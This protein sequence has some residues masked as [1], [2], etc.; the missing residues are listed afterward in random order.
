MHELYWIDT[1]VS[2][3]EVSLVGHEAHQRNFCS[4][5]Q[6]DAKTPDVLE[7]LKLK[8]GEGRITENQICLKCGKKL[9]AIPKAS[10]TGT[11]VF[12][13]SMPTTVCSVKNV[14]KKAGSP[15]SSKTKM[16]DKINILHDN[17]LDDRG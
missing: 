8:Y 9:T 12:C 11:M 7:E 14:L 15:I 16:K 1:E 17:V 13:R 3:T 2:A 5:Q 4:L 6:M 10:M